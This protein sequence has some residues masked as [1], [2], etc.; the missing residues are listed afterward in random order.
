MVIALILLYCMIGAGCTI[1]LLTSLPKSG[2]QR[3]HLDWR[4]VS[5]IRPQAS[6]V[7]VS[8]LRH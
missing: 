7:D 4:G 1:G 5:R 8:R 3:N 6:H 2:I